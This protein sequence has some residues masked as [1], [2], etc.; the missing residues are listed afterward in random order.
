MTDKDDPVVPDPILEDGELDADDDFDT[1]LPEVVPAPSIAP[2][3]RRLV[4]PEGEIV[5]RVDR[6]VADRTGLSRSYVQKLI[7]DGRLVDDAGRRLR[8][9]SEV[10]GGGVTLEVPPPEIPYH[11]E[12]DPT[13]EISVVYEDDDILIVDKQAGLVVH[14]APGHWRGTLVNALLARGDHYGGIAGVARPGIVHR[15]DRDTSGLI[16]VARNDAAQA[17]V[18][19]QLKA[20]RVRKTYL[21]LAQGSVSAAV[22]RIEASIGRDPKDRRR[23]AVVPDGRPSITGYRVRERFAAW[24][25]LELDLVTG[26]THQI[27]VHLAALGHPVA[28]DVVYGTGTSRKGP[29]GLERMFLHAWRLELVSPTSARLVRVEAPLPPALES[30]LEGLRASGSSTGRR[31]VGGTS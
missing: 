20:R 12:P 15:L 16:I 8:A 3:P 18:M 11:L 5:R 27:R 2:G 25:L 1:V 17:G 4:V 13:I 19:A 22:G 28:G 24:T 21:A 6:F 14:P 23:M 10:R 29:D 26:R 30:V 31:A 9:N 7:S